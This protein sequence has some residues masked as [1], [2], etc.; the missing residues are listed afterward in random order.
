M[1]EK[2]YKPK[3]HIKMYVTDEHLEQ[4]KAKAEKEGMTQ[5]AYLYS[6]A[7]KDLKKGVR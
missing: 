4:I 3:S 2:K 6:L 1:K 7:K 5:S